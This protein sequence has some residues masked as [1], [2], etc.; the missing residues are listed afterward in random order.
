MVTIWVTTHQAEQCFNSF[1][2]L[3]SV[4]TLESDPPAP[5]S[6]PATTPKLQMKLE[7]G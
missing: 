4:N 3:G 7:V 2:Y 6:F 5:L 1:V